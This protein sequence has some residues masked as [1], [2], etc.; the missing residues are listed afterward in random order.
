[1]T[2]KNTT[3]DPPEANV[4]EEASVDV[5][6]EISPEPTVTP[7]SEDLASHPEAPADHLTPAPEVGKSKKPKWWHIFAT[8][9]RRIISGI[10][11]ALIVIIGALFAVPATRYAIL[12]TFITKDVTVQVLD[13][14]TNKPVSD[15]ALT[16]GQKSAKT[17][18]KGN[19]TFN[20]VPVGPAHITAKKNYYKDGAA[21]TIVR[22][23][24]APGTVQL[25]LEATGRQVPVKVLNKITGKPIEGAQISVLDTTFSTDNAG[26]TNVVVPADKATEKATLSAKDY[27]QLQADVVVTEQQDAKNT[28]SLTPAGKIY[29]LSKRTGKINVMRSDLDGG[30]QDIVLAGTGK[31]EQTGTV[32][33]AARDWSYLALQAKRDSDKPKLYLVE[34]A[35]G[36]LSVIDEGKATFSPIGWY[37]EWFTYSITRD[38]YSFWQPKQVALKS[39]NAKTGQLVTIDETSAEGSNGNDYARQYFG[40]VYILDN[41]LVYAKAWDASYYSS[42]RL[43]DKRMEIVSVRPD[44]GNKQKLKDF[45]ESGNSEIQTYLSEPQELYFSVREAGVKSYYEYENNK[46][47]QT[48]EFNDDTLATTYY[49]TFLLSPTGK[50]TFWYEPRDGKN[51]LFVGGANANDPKEIASLSELKPYGWYSDDYLLLSKNGSELYILPRDNEAKVQPFKVTDYH[52]PAIEFGGYGYGYGGL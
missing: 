2:N 39:F 43:N 23:F 50:S 30:N 4:H 28:F 27:N 6:K 34:A 48:T 13:S 9:K 1:M 12:G 32:L 44:G 35:T 31:E 47:S 7:E 40:K 3:T 45:A 20:R 42:A 41:L 11:G 29:F 19:A 14:K 10:V 22:V 15:V 24:S 17:D 46:L 25:P 33:L 8:K 38:D 26:E 21:D 36:K 52:K 5:E 37:N 49:P 18:A 51:T 16:L